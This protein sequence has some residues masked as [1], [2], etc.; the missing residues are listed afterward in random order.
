MQQQDTIMRK[1]CTTYGLLTAVA[2]NVAL[3]AL[4]WVSEVPLKQLLTAHLFVQLGFTALLIIWSVLWYFMGYQFR[5]KYLRKRETYRA[6][7]P[8]ADRKNFNQVYFKYHLA[9]NSRAVS[10]VLF[11]AI[12]W[13]FVLQAI[14][15]N[16]HSRDYWI[17][18]SLFVVS[19]LLYGL[20]KRYRNVL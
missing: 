18:G 17:V 20:H 2:W 16:M 9:K 13:Y 5:K 12:P 15:R 10:I 8:K 4:A 19:S 11:T 3:A 7:L 14:N 1:T 6:A